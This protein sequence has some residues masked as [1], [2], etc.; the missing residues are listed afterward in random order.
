[1]Q[2]CR[3]APVGVAA[4]TRGVK[5][6]GPN[7][8]PQRRG[9][10]GQAQGT[11]KSSRMSIPPELMQRM[12]AGGAGPGGS[13]QGGPTGSPAQPAGAPPGMGVQP[14]AAAPMSMPQEKKG[15]KAAAATNVHIA[16]NMLEEAL[17]AFGTES[18]EGGDILKALGILRKHV[19]ARDSSDLVPAEVLQMVRRMPQMGG[20]TSVQQQILRQMRGPQPGPPAA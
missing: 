15:L 3:R 10:C 9:G 16:V 11:S 7:G 18:D 13:P 5:L 2:Y 8:R 4:D 14:P 20:G 1:M 12:M 19:A 17:G 6:G